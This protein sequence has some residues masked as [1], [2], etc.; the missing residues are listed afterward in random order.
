MSEDTVAVVVSAG[1]FAWF[2]ISF[3]L[4]ERRG[5]RSRGQAECAPL[6]TD[7]GA[8]RAEVEAQTNNGHGYETAVL[9]TM[10]ALLHALNLLT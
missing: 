6:D 7:A 9:I 5:R 2:V 1:L 8:T 3:V 4:V 10:I